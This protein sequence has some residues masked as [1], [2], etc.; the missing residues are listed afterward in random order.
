MTYPYQISLITLI[1]WLGLPRTDCHAKSFVLVSCPTTQE[2]WMKFR[3]SM[4]EDVGKGSMA[5]ASADYI[6]DLKECVKSADVK[7]QACFRDPLAA[8]E[9]YGRGKTQL[10]ER[11]SGYEKEPTK[12]ILALDAIPNALKDEKLMRAMADPRTTTQAISDLKKAN[13]S[14]D[15]IR[16]SGNVSSLDN[17]KGTDASFERLLVMVP[18]DSIDRWF[19]I[20]IPTLK[21]EQESKEWS[22][23]SSY[24]VIQKQFA[25][26]A[27]QKAT[28]ETPAK[29]YYRDF[30]R[31]FGD[32][33]GGHFQIQ[34]RG[35]NKSKLTQENCNSC[36]N[37]GLI[38]FAPNPA[39]TLPEYMDAAKRLN[40]KIADYG[41]SLDAHLPPTPYNNPAP[42]GPLESKYRND[43]LMKSCA[44]NLRVE[45]QKRVMS[46]MSCM[47]CHD[48]SNR[49]ILK[50]N[51]LTKG[52][53]G[54]IHTFLVE[55]A[56]MPPGSD[57]NKEEREALARCL[58]KENELESMDLVRGK[59][60]SLD[61]I[62]GIID[63]LNR[64]PKGCP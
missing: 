55:R 51:R 37:G 64:K 13:P 27:V 46:N 19:A 52:E 29:V 23:K 59:G 18:G 43:Q 22:P 6:H 41:V 26:I 11:E 47:E 4:I 50:L 12:S 36:H 21:M 32:G 35:Q 63:E 57:L 42:L 8:L 20:T 45:Q 49:R 5:L 54:I 44:S 31:N 9:K 48:G 24:I 16:F 10:T 1:L 56:Q 7:L 30:D 62:S 17:L 34:T 58:V 33:E 61:T 3:E 38:P 15:V 60:C 40:K 14:F 53:S 28:G 25:E 39:L 2:E